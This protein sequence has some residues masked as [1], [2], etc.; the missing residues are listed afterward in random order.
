MLKAHVRKGVSS[1]PTDCMI[2]VLFLCM[3]GCVFA[4]LKQAT[5]VRACRHWPPDRINLEPMALDIYGS[6]A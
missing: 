6:Y 5:D 4:Q 1:I 2:F 3:F